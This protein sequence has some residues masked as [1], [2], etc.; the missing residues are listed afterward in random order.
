LEVRQDEGSVDNPRS[1]S[2][3][4]PWELLEPK[5]SST[6]ITTI[7]T[8]LP[9]PLYVHFLADLYRKQITIDIQ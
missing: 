6:R 5:K 1:L 8:T 2:K 3:E 4:F 9:L 7:G